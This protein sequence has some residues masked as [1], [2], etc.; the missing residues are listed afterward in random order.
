MGNSNRRASPRPSQSGAAWD[1]ANVLRLISEHKLAPKNGGNNGASNF[2]CPICFLDFGILNT[3][4]CCKQHICTD[5]FVQVKGSNGKGACPFCGNV[6]L[7]A[8][9]IP[10]EKI[11]S[12]TPVSNHSALNPTKATD[13]RSNSINSETDHSSN[14]STKPLSYTTP[15]QEKKL[16]SY[17]LDDTTPSDDKGLNGTNQRLASKNDRELLERQIR[18]QRLQFD[19]RDLAEATAR[20]TRTYRS[21]NQ[22]GAMY[23]RQTVRTRYGTTMNSRSAD[24]E[25]ISGNEDTTNSNTD[26]TNR[27]T[28]SPN[29]N[30]GNIEFVNSL[31]GLLHTHGNTRITSIQQLE[32][33]MLM[34]AIRLSMQ[35]TTPSTTTTDVTNNT[36]TIPPSASHTPPSPFAPLSP[37]QSSSVRSTPVGQTTTSAGSPFRTFFTTAGMHTGIES[38]EDDGSS[39]ERNE[40]HESEGEDE[41]DEHEERVAYHYRGNGTLDRYRTRESDENDEEDEDEE[42]RQI[43]LAMELSLAEMRQTAPTNSEAMIHVNEDNSNTGIDVN[44]INFT[45]MNVASSIDT[46]GHDPDSLANRRT[47]DSNYHTTPGK[48]LAEELVLKPHAEE[49]LPTASSSDGLETE[50]NSINFEITTGSNNM[51][52]DSN[53]DVDLNTEISSTTTETSLTPQAVFAE[54][55]L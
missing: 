29:R 19:E 44:D 10:M 30:N 31:E 27:R 28:H 37:V 38:G 11:K 34:E 41:D 20:S 21:T 1:E 39:E 25:R 42:E 48:L 15:E 18:E 32:D 24:V 22:S 17:S 6:E 52:T 49:T 40:E 16:R 14:G 23:F 4:N 12:S 54:V 9:L 51:M 53:G 13:N 35:E 2:E 55:R 5:C 7:N 50:P 33:L 46:A 45:T 26:G 3:V 47:A 43:K 36:T 8:S